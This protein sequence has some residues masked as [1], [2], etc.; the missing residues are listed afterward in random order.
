MF[1]RKNKYRIRSV[2]VCLLLLCSSVI[3]GQSLYGD[4]PYEQSL[5]NGS[6][7]DI[8]FPVSQQPASN[9]NQAAFLPNIGLQLTPASQYS[10]GAIF[11]DKRQFS[12]GMGIKIEF[13]YMMYDGTGGDGMTMFLFDASIPQNQLEIGA[14]GAGIGYAYNRSYNG[15]KEIKG[16]YIDFSK[17][18]MKGLNGAYLGVAL[19]EFGNYK[20]LRLQSDSRVNGIPYS[21]TF[22]GTTRGMKDGKYN[23]QNQVTLRAGK[24]PTFSTAGLGDRYT[25]YPVLITQSTNNRD[26]YLGN[27]TI[28]GFILD[29]AQNPSKYDLITNYNGELFTISGGS[30]FTDPSD[31]AYRKAII[32]L[33]PAPRVNDQT[34]GFLVTVSI[35]HGQRTDVI[36]SDYHYKEKFWYAENAIPDGSGGDNNG[37]DLARL[38]PPQREL[39]AKI[40]SFL[41]IGFAAATGLQTNRHIIKHLKISLPRAAEADDDFASTN[42]NVSVSLLPL[43]NDIAYDGPIS[44]TQIGQPHYIDVNTFRFRSIDGTVITG[45]TY[46]DSDGN[47]WKFTYENATSPMDRTVRVTLTPHPSFSGEAKIKYDILGGRFTPDPYAD[48]AYRSLSATITVE[49]IK[50]PIVYRNTISN[51]MVTIKMK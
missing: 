36:I 35:Q 40:P 3:Y 41:R 16:Q 21:G 33:F 22:S 20:G 39:D 14:H 24:G 10:F 27:N 37:D 38:D 2:I 42:Q 34:D 29:G 1:I 28:P 44:K 13:E 50:S 32:E 8:E 31:P 47:T 43:E 9:P 12:S 46:T 48:P 51:K 6:V 19:D 7:P 30:H 23:T 45:D 49:V 26:T 15:I 11:V 25:G 18:R 4:F 17:Y 5:L